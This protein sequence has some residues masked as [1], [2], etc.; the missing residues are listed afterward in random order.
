MAEIRKSLTID[1]TAGELFDIVEDPSKLPKF[2][3]NVSEVVD[4]QRTD[5]RVGDTFRVIY[6][7]LGLTF[8]EQFTTTEY[9]RPTYLTAAFKGGMNG[10]FRWSFEPHGTQCKVNVD[11]H[12]DVAGGALGKA[13][14]AVM[15]ERTNAKAIEGMLDNLRRMVVKAAS[16]GG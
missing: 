11:I 12:Y 4:I 1:A 2:V 6:K 15:L 10:T 5:R 9:D 3:P 14:D 7:V 16:S 8:D 13:V